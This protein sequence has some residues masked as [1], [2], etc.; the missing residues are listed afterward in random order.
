[1]K[2]AKSQ[3]VRAVAEAAS[4]GAATLAPSKIDAKAVVRRSLERLYG[5]S[6]NNGADR[7]S[8]AQP[9]SDSFRVRSASLSGPVTTKDSHN[10][11][12]TNKKGSNTAPAA[13]LT[14]ADKQQSETLASESGAEFE[15]GAATCSGSSKV[16]SQ[17][18]SP[19]GHPSLP[20]SPRTPRGASP[21]PQVLDSP[22]STAE[23]AEGKTDKSRK[24]KIGTKAADLFARLQTKLSA[25]KT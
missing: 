7:E 22:N 10:P 5:K 16:P 9:S 8:R 2:A 4:E 14:D 1:M 24:I 12:E 6:N 11:P 18:A 23:Y 25:N 3:D 20:Q 21:S 17:P 15:T 13:L 19:R